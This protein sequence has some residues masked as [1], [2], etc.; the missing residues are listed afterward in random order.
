MTVNHSIAGIARK[1]DL[2][3]IAKR[4]E[5]GALSLKWE[6]PGGK[7]EPGESHEEAI[8]REW[9]EEFKIDVQAGKFLCS[10]SFTHKNKVFELSAYD[11]DLL[12]EDF[13]LLEHTEI[14]WETLHVISKMDLADSDRGILTQLIEMEKKPS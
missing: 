3:L 10:G 1:G 14:R 6:F 4:K 9:D 11:V 7:L 12:S 5:G 2:Y 8:V 13:T